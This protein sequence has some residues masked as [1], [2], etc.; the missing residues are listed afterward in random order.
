MY[1][2]IP[3][4]GPPREPESDSSSSDETSSEDEPEP[5]RRDS[6]EIL[7]KDSSVA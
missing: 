7:D 4:F 3:T 5:Y 6:P 2:A 1:P